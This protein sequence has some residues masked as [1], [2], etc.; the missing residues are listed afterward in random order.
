MDMD[1]SLIQH[2]AVA[3]DLPKGAADNLHYLMGLL[4]P[5]EQF[6]LGVLER[7]TGTVSC[8]GLLGQTLELTE[9]LLENEPLRFKCVTL[10][11]GMGPYWIFVG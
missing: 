6:A 4:N 3:G 7:V 9:V 10:L 2:L 5:A 11:E 1:K 8:E